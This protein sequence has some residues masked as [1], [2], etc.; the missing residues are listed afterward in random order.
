MIKILQIIASIIVFTV[1]P[2]IA[3]DNYFKSGFLDKFMVEQS[4]SLMGTILAIYIAAA[5]SFIAILTTHED[6]KKQK[7][8]DK[9]TKELKQSIIFV[10]VVFILHFFLLVAT[11][12][13]GESSISKEVIILLKG[14]KTLTFML[15]IYA[16]F[17]LSSELFTLK[18]KL[19]KNF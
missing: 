6:Q 13:A 3:L 16:L 15:Y 14:I 1:L 17:E 7:I 19:D 18:N 10:F 8:F 4:L 9:T 12:E 5:S 11:P 2:T